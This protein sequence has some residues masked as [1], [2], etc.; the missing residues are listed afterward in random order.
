ML[1][2][3]EVGA[4]GGGVGK[5]IRSDLIGSMHFARC[6]ILPFIRRFLLLNVLS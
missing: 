1:K 3:M 6:K 2:S 4:G 5:S